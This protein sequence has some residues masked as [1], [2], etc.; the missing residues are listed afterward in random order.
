VIYFF[1]G[2]GDDGYQNIAPDLSNENYECNYYS[3]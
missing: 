2:E 3:K 1:N